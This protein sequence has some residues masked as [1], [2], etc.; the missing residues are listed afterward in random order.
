MIHYKNVNGALLSF[1]HQ[2]KLALQGG[3]N[4]RRNDRSGSWPDAEGC[5]N[6]VV[7]GPS[8]ADARWAATGD[9][10]LSRFEPGPVFRRTERE[11][12][13]LQGLAVKPQCEPVCQQSLQAEHLLVANLFAPRHRGAGK[14]PATIS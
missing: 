6:S 11:D 7:R 12:G 3:V 4:R 1:Q 2:A 13:A 10:T 9:G 5:G 8:Q 14:G